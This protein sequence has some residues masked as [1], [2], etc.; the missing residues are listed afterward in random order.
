MKKTLY[1]RKIKYNPQK[2]KDLPGLFITCL[3]KEKHVKTLK[4]RLQRVW[5]NTYKHYT[6]KSVSMIPHHIKFLLAVYEEDLTLRLDKL[7]HSTLVHRLGWGGGGNCHFFIVVHPDE[8]RRTD[9]GVGRRE[10]PVPSVSSVCK[11][12]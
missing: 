11:T 4:K 3:K 8:W 10:S 12:S 6:Q 9:D 7:T 2:S 5:S 1:P